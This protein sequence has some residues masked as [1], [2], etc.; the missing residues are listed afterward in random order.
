MSFISFSDST[1]LDP[2]FVEHP[3]AIAW[4]VNSKYFVDSEEDQLCSLSLAAG[5]KLQENP[6][7]KEILVED[8]LYVG[9]KCG[10]I[11]CNP[12]QILSH[13]LK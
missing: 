2:G 7:L 5:M 3:D 8:H 11:N 10:Y 6:L 13:S 4:Q 1:Q 12:L 9:N